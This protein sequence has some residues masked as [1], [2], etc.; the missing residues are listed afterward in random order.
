MRNEMLSKLHTGHQGIEKCR[1]RA[2]QVIFWPKINMDIEK[3]I[4]SCST[5]QK[6]QP[7]QPKEPMTYPDNSNQPWQKVGIDLF[8]IENN[9]YIVGVDYYSQFIEVC[10]LRSSSSTAVINILKSWFAVHGTPM[11]LVSDNGPQF[12]SEEFQKFTN[13]WNIN[14]TTSSTYFAQYNGQ[15]ENAVKIVKAMIKKCTETFT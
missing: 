4:K 11:F 10:Q 9:N 14:Q 1:R 8:T 6:H 5:C 15:A 12:A 3:S 13:Y 2:R 7:M